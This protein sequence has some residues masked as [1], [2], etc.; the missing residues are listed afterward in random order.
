MPTAP[1]WIWCGF[2]YRGLDVAAA[3]LDELIDERPDMHTLRALRATLNFQQGRRDEA[4]AEMEAL[5]AREEEAAE[6]GEAEE[7]TG[8]EDQRRQFQVT[9]A[10]MLAANGN[11]VGA[12]RLVEEILEA[13]PRNVGALK[14][15]ARWLIDEDSTD[16]AINALRTALSEAPEDADAMTLMAEAHERAGNDQLRMDF[17]SL[18]FEASNKTPE[19]TVRY[20]RALFADGRIDQAE[21]ALIDSIRLHPDNESLLALVGQ[22]Y[23]RQDDS[24]RT[25]QVIRRLRELD[26]ETAR[27]AADSLDLELISR[28]SGNE[29]ALAFLEQVAREGSDNDRAKLALIEGLIR[30][31]RAED[32][33]G[34]VEE[35]VTENPDNDGYQLF[36]ALT[37]TSIGRHEEAEDLLGDLVERDPLAVTAWLQLA[38]IRRITGTPEDMMETLDAA[39]EVLPQAGDLLWAKASLLEGQGD[40][41][42]AIGIY[43]DLYER[44]SGSPIIANN[45]ASMLTTYR[46][47][48]ESLER[49]R[50]IARRLRNADAPAFQ[51]TYGWIL[52]RSGDSEEAISY[53]EPA[54]EAL[55]ADPM[56]QVHLGLAY[57]AVGRTDDA[58]SQLERARTALGP[59]PSEQVRDKLA[60]LE[61]A[62]AG[63]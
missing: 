13:D 31:G 62:L 34:Y 63:E 45:L 50:V 28:E 37:L 11:E 52:H 4:I 25:R 3:E 2:S 46:D 30:T 40:I 41:D 21:S 47:D 61:T 49:A 44:Y 59:V 43:E 17:L 58:R 15:Q 35:L 29:E 1:I 10:R 56:V 26:T 54:A 20:A 60:E 32:A 5:V 39:L 6:E 51:D 19:E 9:L 38:R 18:A 57:V 16:E 22:V 33:L 7:G 48:P 14:L 23:L 12:R 55:T 42:A 36:K 53:L 27:N 24:A 8:G